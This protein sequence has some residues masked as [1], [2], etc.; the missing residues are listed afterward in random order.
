[1]RKFNKEMYEMW[2]LIN[3][4]IYSHDLRVDANTAAEIKRH[5]MAA[6]VCGSLLLFLLSVRLLISAGG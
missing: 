5:N 2:G 4:D 1:M 3:G 6:Q